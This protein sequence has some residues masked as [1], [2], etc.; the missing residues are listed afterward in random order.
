[1]LKGKN[2]VLGVCGGIA[3]YKACDLVSQLKKMGANIDIIM[4]KSATEFVTELTFRTLSANP[5]VTDMFDSPTSWDVKHIS[6]A[7]KADLFLIVPATANIIGKISNAIADDMLSTTVMATKAPVILC[8]AMNT[9]MYENPLV[10]ENIKKLKNFGYEFIEPQEGR[11]ACGDIGKGKLA[12]IETIISYVE[13]KLYDKKDLKNK[14]VL[15][16]AGPTIES[17]DPVRYITN[18]SSGKMGYALANKAALRGAKVI[19]ISGKT[20]LAPSE[21]IQE[22]IFVES[23][24]EMYN[25]VLENFN[26][27][28]IVIKSAAVAD[29][30]PKAFSNKKIKKSDSDLKIDLDRNPDIL[31]ELGSIKGSKVLVGFAAET[32]D[33]I[34]NAKSKIERKNLDFIVANDL[35]LEGAGFAVDTNIVKI[36]EP[37]GRI[38]ELPKISK[39][40]LADKILDKALEKSNS[41]K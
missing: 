21:N 19:L 23:A 16:T 34:E 7:Q 13:K 2:I 10:Q 6:L 30:K 28:D 17:I 29:Y 14:T 20:N 33:L 9:G 26:E 18:R 27:A 8:P 31:K 40:D 5:V 15:V 11:L 37:D 32:N 12:K 39:Q 3:V 1:M 25:K 24:R 22:C 38:L 36:I 41:K 35:S 4:T